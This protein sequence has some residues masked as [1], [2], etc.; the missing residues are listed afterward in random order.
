M[1][2]SKVATR[3]DS[4]STAHE[5]PE[6]EYDRRLTERK[7]QLAGIRIL[8]SRLW[9]YLGAAALAGM[10]VV[11]VAPFAAPDSEVLDFAAFDSG[12]IHLPDAY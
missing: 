5:I 6:R 3:E 12:P 2:T 4:A 11:W 10:I 9:I 1:S 7:R 8:H